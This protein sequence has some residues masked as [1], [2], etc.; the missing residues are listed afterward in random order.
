MATDGERPIICP[1][2][3]CGYRGEPELLKEGGANTALAVF[4]LLIAIVPGLIYVA[5]AQPKYSATCPRCRVNLGRVEPPKEGMSATTLVLLIGLAGAAALVAL[6]AFTTSGST[7]APPDRATSALPPAD[8]AASGEGRVVDHIAA[9]LVEADEE[10]Y[11]FGHDD[12][13]PGLLEARARF[14]AARA[15]RG[16]AAQ[17]SDA[18]GQARQRRIVMEEMY[19][20]I[21]AELATWPGFVL[22]DPPPLRCDELPATGDWWRRFEHHWDH[23]HQRRATV[24]PPGSGPPLAVAAAPGMRS[25]VCAHG[26]TVQIPAAATCEAWGC[27]APSPRIPRTMP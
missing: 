19:P 3:N 23:P 11:R 26:R 27:A 20:A 8:P 1:N 6:L 14:N 12:E 21:C 5:L 24:A 18:V 7:V 4:L 17:A 13:H 25:C 9:A 15:R 22:P 2:T 16:V 10:I